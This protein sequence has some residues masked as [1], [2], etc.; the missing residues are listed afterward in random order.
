MPGMSQTEL[1]SSAAGPSDVR[2]VEHA[3]GSVAAP[4][5]DP[6]GEHAAEHAADAMIERRY[7]SDIDRL[8]EVVGA[9]VLPHY[10][11]EQAIVAS[12]QASERWPH[13]VAVA[14]ARAGAASVSPLSQSSKHS[15]G[16]R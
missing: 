4:A 16:T 13:L 7:P 10:R 3:A 2:M 15:A 5:V 8:R 1:S 6:V 14:N 9:D 12:E 11:D